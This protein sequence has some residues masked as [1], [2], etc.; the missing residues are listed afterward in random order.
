VFAEL[1][2]KSKIVEKNVAKIYKNGKFVI[3]HG[4]FRLYARVFETILKKTHKPLL[5][6]LRNI[7]NYQAVH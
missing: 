1:R 5:R 4:V 3:W 2:E 7:K 6:V